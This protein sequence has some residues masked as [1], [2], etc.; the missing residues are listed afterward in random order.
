[1]KKTAILLILSLAFM[2]LP[3][4]I[5]KPIS[6]APT[7]TAM[8]LMTYNVRYLNSSDS[9]PHTWAERLPAIVKLIQKEKP[10]I[11]GTQEGVYQQIQNL[12]ASL[13][14]YNWVG[15]GREGGSSG[16]YTA[17]FYR[18]DRYELLEYNFFWLSDTPGTVGSKNWG[19]VISRL[20]TWAKFSDRR[21]NQS[22]YV[23]NTHFDHVSAEARE[24][25]SA[26]ILEKIKDFDPALPILLTGDFNAAPSSPPYQLLTREGAFKDSWKTAAVRINENL[27]TLNRFKDPTGEGPKRRI[28]WILTKGNVLADSVKIVNDYE[29]GQFPSDHFPVVADLLIKNAIIGR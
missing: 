18:T 21:T 27:G 2:L 6:A 4:T 19:N 17:I 16:E 13:P 11:I 15:I 29:N 26:L 9:S 14:E 12:D 23:I 5:I 3:S 24:K 25:S 22:F 7:D 20:V 1:M 10:D 28:D 8:R